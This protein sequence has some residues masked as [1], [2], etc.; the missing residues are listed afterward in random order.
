M[1][2]LLKIDRNAAITQ[3]KALGYTSDDLVY[4]RFFVPGDDPRKST[5][6]GRKIQ[7][8]VKSIPWQE[9][10]KNQRDGRGVYFV[11]NGGGHEDKDVQSCRAIFTEHDDLPK[12]ESTVLWRSLGLPEPTNQV[13]TGGKSI[14]TYWVFD[15]PI[16]VDQWRELQTDLLEF[17]DGDRKLKNPSRV[18]RLAGA[19]HI[20]PGREPFQ[21]T[22]ISNSGKQY[23]FAE[24]RAIV[25]S[26]QQSEPGRGSG[27]QV[28]WAKF[29]RNFRLPIT[30]SVPLSECL[31][32]THRDLIERGTAEGGRNASGY[33][34]AADLIGT[35]QHLNNI[36][37]RY[38]EDPRQLFEL[39]L[40]KCT[41]PLSG[42]EVESIW[43]SA[44]QRTT[45][46]ALSPEQIEGCIKGWSWRQVRGQATVTPALAGELPGQQ[47]I[48]DP[49][50]LCPIAAN[51]NRLKTLL[52]DRLRLNSL[53]KE[54]ELDG[55]PVSVERLELELALKFNKQFKFLPTISRAVAEENTYSPVVEYLERVAAQHSDNV[56]ILDGIAH[57]YFGR[58]DLQHFR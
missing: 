3:L 48:D 30:E 7:A 57:R 31:S 20:K 47:P 16:S 18:M 32:R 46:P 6:K 4:L 56:S 14:H 25:P 58:A 24:L 37:Q 11:V 29:D 42:S 44:S 35:A 49:E 10:E 8:K 41:P 13:D 1:S 2:N 9:I 33:A 39:F 53:T 34:L 23:S 15:E 50:K 45:G 36:G 27:E 21:S 19:Y 55:N 17:T 26:R 5:D 43:K 52:G 12:E 40:A 51:Y 28:S 22:V 38:Q 54:L